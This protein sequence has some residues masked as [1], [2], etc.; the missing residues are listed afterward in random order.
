MNIQWY[1]HILGRLEFPQEHKIRKILENDCL[2]EIPDGDGW[3]CKPIE[4]YNTRTYTMTPAPD[5]FNCNCQGFQ[6]KLRDGKITPYC[7][8]VNALRIWLEV[9]GGPG[10]EQ[11]QLSLGG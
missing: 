5:G 7:S 10:Q 3:I 2:Q 9:H 6:K 11:R 4:G 1:N 8:H